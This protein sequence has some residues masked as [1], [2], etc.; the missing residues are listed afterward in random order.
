MKLILPTGTNIFTLFSRI[1][2][3]ISTF[4]HYRTHIFLKKSFLLFI[5]VLQVYSEV[6]AVK[7]I[8]YYK[9]N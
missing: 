4:W 8:H 9:N 1:K 3:S 6:G 5:T 2:Q 7:V